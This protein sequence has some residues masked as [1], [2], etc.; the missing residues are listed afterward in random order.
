MAKT[1]ISLICRTRRGLFSVREPIYKYLSTNL[2]PP[3][4]EAAHEKKIDGNQEIEYLKTQ[5]EEFKK[6]EQ[7]I[8]NYMKSAEICANF[9]KGLI[10][11]SIGFC[12]LGLIS[13]FID[14]YERD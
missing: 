11:G 3:V 8:L 1:M 13:P 5:I 4:N 2:V 12:M 14:W 6:N 9:G 10:L 7:K